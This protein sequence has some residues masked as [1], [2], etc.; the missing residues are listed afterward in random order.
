MDAS[1]RLTTLTRLGFAAR[2][3]L[4][5]IIA[6]LVIQSGRTEDPA[7]ALG[8]VAS[9]AGGWLLDSQGG[10]HSTVGQS[11]VTAFGP[12]VGETHRIAFLVRKAGESGSGSGGGSASAVRSGSSS[13]G[14]GVGRYM[15]SGMWSSLGMRG[16]GGGGGNGDSPSAGGGAG[17]EGN[18]ATGMGGF[19]VDAR[20]YV[21]GLLSLN[22]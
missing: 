19:G 7:G 18:G 5:I 22:R 4:Y 10:A 3:V 17:E 21:E 6:V 8:Y 9:G 20:K 13:G 14:G 12:S 16:L 11:S 15:G 1:A 2:G